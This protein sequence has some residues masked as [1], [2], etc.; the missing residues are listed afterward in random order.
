M[1][2]DIDYTPGLRTGGVLFFRLVA[3][4]GVDGELREDLAGAVFDGGDV[5]VPDEQDD[6]FVFVGAADAEVS[7]ASGVA[8]GDLAVGVDTV[9]ADPPVFPLGGDGGGGLGGR[10]VRLGGCAAFE[11]AVRPFVVVDVAEFGQELVQVRDGV[12]LGLV[13]EPFFEGLVETFDL[14]L[15]LGVAG[16]GPFFWVMPRDAMRV[17]KALRPPRPPA[18]RVV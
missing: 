18:R 11:G 12:G 7:E 14:A 1:S 3:A 2:R 8:K 16:G 6:A 5:G 10:F 9:G 13:F 4:G 15:G 17:S